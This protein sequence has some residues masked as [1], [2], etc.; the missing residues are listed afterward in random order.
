MVRPLLTI[1]TA[2]VL[3]AVLLT[4]THATRAPAAGKS[5]LVTFHRSGGFIGVDD[6]V[7]VKSNRRFTV[8]S[9][10]SSARHKRL[11]V[12]AMRKLRHALKEARLD[13][14]LAQGP[15]SGCADCFYYTITY[16]G[17]RVQLS[18]DRVPDRMRPAINRL[19]RLIG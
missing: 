1:V 18:E 6:R 7:T 5:T 3:A 4:A 11:S 14:P 9:R 10:G 17:H 12:A 2:A 13:E 8:R 16:Q 19:S 15:P